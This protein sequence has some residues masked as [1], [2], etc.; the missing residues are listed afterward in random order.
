MDKNYFCITIC[1]E[2]MCNK[3]IKGQK[4]LCVRVKF[5]AFNVLIN[6]KSKQKMI[7][8]WFCELIIFKN[9]L[10]PGFSIRNILLQFLSGVFGYFLFDRQAFIGLLKV[11]GI[12]NRMLIN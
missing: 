12:Q 9:M 7:G 2:L 10:K 8:N 1:S 5:L 6:P 3:D 11:I 4:S